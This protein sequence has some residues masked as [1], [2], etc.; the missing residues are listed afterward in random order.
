MKLSL[1]PLLLPFPLLS[2]TATGQVVINE[3]MYDD[4]GTD[5]REF[6]ELYNAGSTEVAIGGWR[7]GGYDATTTNPSTTIPAGT[8]LAAGAYYVIGNA[9]VLNLNHQVSA[10]QFENDNEVITLRDGGGVLV[11]AVAYETNKGLGFIT[12]GGGATPPLDPAAVLEQLGPGFFGNFQCVDAADTP[13]NATL[14]FGRFVDGRDTNNNGRDFGIRPSTPGTT[15]APGGQ[16]AEFIFP[17]PALLATGSAMPGMGYS[18]APLRVMDP[19]VVDSNNP[20][21][22]APPA[23]AGS[24]AYALWDPSGGG[25]AAAS[26]SIFA[27]KTS[28]FS[29]YVY[30]DTTDLPIQTNTAGTNFRGS[31]VTIYGIGSG[32]ALNNLT[33]LDGSL[34]VGAGTLPGSDT[35]NGCTG[36]AWVYER[37][38]VT[39]GGTTVSEKLHLVDANDGGDSDLAGNTPL[40]WTILATYDLS[41]TDSGWFPLS[42]HIDAAGN[43]TAAFNGQV[44]AFNAG[45]MHSGCFHVNY[46]ENLQLG[47]ADPVPEH[48]MRPATFTLVPVPPAA[49]GVLS[50]TSMTPGAINMSIPVGPGQNIGIEYSSSLA[51]GSWLDIGGVTVAAGIG[52]FSD[53]DAARLAAGR[54][55]Y[56]AFLRDA[57]AE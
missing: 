2:L 4:G 31:E 1:L 9:G 32:D 51:T 41:S 30:F 57:A 50:F 44:T 15:N 24:K 47:A 22:I 21:V 3:V 29:L 42:I 27:G 12:T 23:G 25:D 7:L 34:E 26:A 16:V 52:T 49:I 48:L 56:R 5:D 40:D 37:A 17:D 43:G 18:F 45:D 54:G 53:T 8:M 46:R 33:D 55:F 35:A 28:G 10:N 19:A 11:D 38:G 39:G 13:L 36:I 6:V 20:N 14:S